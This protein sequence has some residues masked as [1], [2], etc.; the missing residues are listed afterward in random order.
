[1]REKRVEQHLDAVVRAA[2]GLTFKVA[3]THAGLPDRMVI[4]DGRVE[5]VELKAPGGKLRPVQVELHRRIGERGVRVHVLAS[6]EEVD[7][8]I[9]CYGVI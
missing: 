8:W 4:L 2:G 5:L 7:S 3:P 6:I 9:A 1:M